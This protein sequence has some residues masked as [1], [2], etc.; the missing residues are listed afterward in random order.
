[1][2]VNK[3]YSMEFIGLKCAAGKEGYRHGYW[4]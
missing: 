4:K 3:N 1:M 2:A